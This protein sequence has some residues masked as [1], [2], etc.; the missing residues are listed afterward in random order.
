MKKSLFLVL[1][2][3]AFAALSLPLSSSIARAAPDVT[4]LLATGLFF[5]SR[6]P[7]LDSPAQGS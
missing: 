5:T 4:S 7:S 1:A 3:T 2:A 6:L